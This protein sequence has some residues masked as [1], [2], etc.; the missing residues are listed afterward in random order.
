M[1]SRETRKYPNINST[2]CNHAKISSYKFFRT[3]KVK[4]FDHAK[5]IACY[6]ID[7]RVRDTSTVHISFFSM[8]GPD[9]NYFIPKNTETE[10]QEILL[11]TI[12]KTR[13]R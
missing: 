8:P 5:I 2:C 6:E 3:W 9:S 10:D 1:S 7:S 11:K 4:Q 12:A 13:V